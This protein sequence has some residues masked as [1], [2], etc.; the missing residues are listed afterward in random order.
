MTK[1]FGE[2]LV[3]IASSALALTIGFWIRTERELPPRSDVDRSHPQAL[4]LPSVSLETVD[5]R[6]MRLDSIV[7]GRPS[8]VLI[9][10]AVDCLGCSNYGPELRSI[11]ESFPH[12]L[13]ILVVSGRRQAVLVR[14]YL[15]A[16]GLAQSGGYMDTHDALLRSLGRAPLALL[17]DR[18]GRV[19]HIE[20]GPSR[21]ATPWPLAQTLRALSCVL[22]NVKTESPAECEG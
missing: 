8:V 21:A 16:N 10:S 2:V 3:V 19:V 18:H 22:T 4:Q 5:N 17:V 13:S 9:A 20:R 1:R 12:I 15:R 7:S 6:V 14:R 11:R